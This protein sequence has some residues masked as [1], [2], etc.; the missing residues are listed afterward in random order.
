MKYKLA[1]LSVKRSKILGSFQKFL[2]VLMVKLEIYNNYS[3][4]K[5]TQMNSIFNKSIRNNENND[6]I[7]AWWYLVLRWYDASPVVLSIY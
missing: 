2:L 7:T 6:K 4:K 1:V 3:I 5:G